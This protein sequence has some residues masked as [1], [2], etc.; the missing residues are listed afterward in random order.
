MGVSRKKVTIVGA[1]VA[2]LACAV[3][4]HEAG[5]D[6]EVREAGDSVGGRVRSDRLD[7]FTLDRGFQ[8]FLT[9]YPEAR[10]LLDYEALGLGGFV[11][12]A[13]VWTGRRF[14]RAADP[15]RAPAYALATATTG[16]AT[17][18]DK[19]ALGK[20]WADLR[21]LD[22]EEL[23]GGPEETTLEYL[24]GRGFSEMILDRFFRPFFGGVFLEDELATSGRLF[25]FLFRCF[26]DGRATLPAA[27]IGAIP[28]QLAARLPDGA[29]RLNTP[30][31]ALKD[32]EADA[33]IV[34]TDADHAA[35]LLDQPR[36][37]TRWHATTCVYLAADRS[38]MRGEPILALDGT[39]VGPVNNVAVL[40]DAQ[41]AYAPPGASLVSVNLLGEHPDA[42]PAARRQVAAWF[43]DDVCR[44]RHLRTDVIHRA[45]PVQPPGSLAPQHKPAR[46]RPGLYAAGDWLDT[47]SLNGALASGRR[48]AEA[49]LHDLRTSRLP[50]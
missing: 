21:R 7:G 9:S 23:L 24:R 30:V 31:D 18:G 45:L 25:R 47:A 50:A 3:R 46:V 37:S 44:W 20:L 4:L 39:G 26:A 10:E 42:E 32:V 2:G 22:F 15:L 43:G 11:P 33:V 1:G 49:L 34:A 36:A 17:L 14:D 6:V 12:G 40:S 5:L 35:R 28:A 8:V 29:V 16:V 48:A 38:P 13:A 19:I 41:P 27:G